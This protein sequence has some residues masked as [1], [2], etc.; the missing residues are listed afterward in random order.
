MNVKGVFQ[1]DKPTFRKRSFTFAFGR[2]LL[3]IGAASGLCL[4]LQV[5]GLGGV[6]FCVRC[7]EEFE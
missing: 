2:M 4:G 1:K 6:Q 7:P 3:G 5:D